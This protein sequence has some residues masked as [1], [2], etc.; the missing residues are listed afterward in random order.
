M[1]QANGCRAEGGGGSKGRAF[2]GR[3]GG[4]RAGLRGGVGAWPIAAVSAPRTA[5]GQRR[6]EPMVPLSEFSAPCETDVLFGLGR[7]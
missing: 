2:Q 5:D 6:P 4:A 7:N 3:V 1:D